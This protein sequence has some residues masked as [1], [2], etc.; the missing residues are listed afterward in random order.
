M[1]TFNQSFLTRQKDIIPLEVMNTPITVIGAGA[2]GSHTVMSLARMGFC[3]I[4]LYDGDNVDD[5]NFNNQGYFL[6]QMGCN[7]ATATASNVY[8]AI[9]INIK[10][11]PKMFCADDKIP[12]DTILISAVDSMSARKMIYVSTN[13]P[14]LIDPRMAAEK[15]LLHVVNR[16]SKHSYEKTLHTDENSM[17]ENCTAKA[18]I[19]C[20]SL[21]SGLV[22][23][24][25]K[26]I[27]TKRSY[28][29]VM[30]WDIENNKVEYSYDGYI[31]KG[32]E[33]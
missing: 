14:W 8:N 20:A 3:N 21:L 2:V 5:V 6:N 11:I 19:Y 30:F 22:A 16:Y 4:T 31:N 15:A 32:E 23:K 26:D 7:K 27:V 17:R 28:T 25:V 29:K 10:A 18:T 13:T 33:E 24:A 12:L 9:G 1:T